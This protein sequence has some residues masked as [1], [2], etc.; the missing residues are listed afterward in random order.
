MPLSLMKTGEHCRVSAVQ[1]PADVSRRLTN[2]GFTAGEPV[3][4]VGKCGSA[5][6]VCVRDCRIALDSGTAYCICVSELN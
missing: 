5:V 1:G 6:I 3:T 4:V 2:L